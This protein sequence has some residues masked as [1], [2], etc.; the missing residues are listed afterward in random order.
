MTIQSAS[1]F[2]ILDSVDSTNNYAMAMVREGMAKHGMAIVAKEQ[3]AGKGQRGKSWQMRP[4]QSI[5]MSIILKTDKLRTDQ[6]FYLNMLIALAAN[7]FLKKYAGKETTIKWPNDLYWR[8][9]KAGGI[10]IETV[11]K[12]T[13]WKWA[14]VGIGIN[15]NQNRFHKSLPNPVS[16]QQIT[17]KEY[18][19]IVLAEELHTAVMKRIEMIAV[20]AADK[21]KKEYTRHLYKMDTIVKLKKASAVFKTTIKGVTEQGQLITADTMERHFDFGEVEWVI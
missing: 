10:L 8:D 14:V 4:G 5:A 7:D 15:V 11:F 3:T 20:T 9:R 2:K 18:D 16:L 21:V 1:F 17:G 12:G 13:G 6:Q 19:V